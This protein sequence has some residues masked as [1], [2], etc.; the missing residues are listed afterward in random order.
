[1]SNYQDLEHHFKVVSQYHVHL[2]VTG[3]SFVRQADTHYFRTALDAFRRRFEAMRDS[4]IT[5]SVWKPD[6]KRSLERYPELVI[7][8]LDEAEMGCDACHLGG[9]MSKYEGTLDGSP[10]DGETFE[11]SRRCGCSSSSAL[12]GAQ[13]ILGFAGH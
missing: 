5:S 2:V 11:V 4:L 10:Y 12:A 1:M 8:V 13:D 7:G 6:F 3:P 9:R